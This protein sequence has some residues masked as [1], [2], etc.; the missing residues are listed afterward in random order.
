MCFDI[1]NASEVHLV[2][3]FVNAV[4][5]IEPQDAGGVIKKSRDKE[6]SRNLD[7]AATSDR[8]D[9]KDVR[10]SRSVAKKFCL[11]DV[12]VSAI[13]LSP[14]RA[15]HRGFHVAVPRILVFFEGL[16]FFFVVLPTRCL[17]DVSCLFG[18][19]LRPSAPVF[20]CHQDSLTR[21]RLASEQEAVR[22]SSFQFPRLILHVMTCGY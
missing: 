9:W 1:F 13:F 15:V 11:H 14:G 3:E 2:H 7:T 22:V 18:L 17:H 12:R 6:L 21:G 10:S 4:P 19:T 8:R 16:L 5:G 20:C